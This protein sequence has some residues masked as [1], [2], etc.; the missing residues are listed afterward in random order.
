MGRS[1]HRPW[2]QPTWTPD[3]QLN[4]VEPRQHF[5]WRRNVDLQ[6]TL[7]APGLAGL[8][9]PCLFLGVV[10]GTHEG[11]RLHVP[12]SEVFLA[13]PFPLGELGWCY[14]ASDWDVLHR[15][16][17]I[18]AQ[19]EDVDRRLAKVAHRLPDLARFLIALGIPEVGVTVARVL[20]QH[21]GAIEAIRGASVEQLEAVDGI[22]PKM[23][24]T[25][26]TFL[27]DERNTAAIDAILDRGVVPVGPEPLPDELPDAGAAVFTGTIPIP[28]AAA[29][30]AWRAVGGRTVSSV[31]KKTDYV[32]AGGNAGSKL[33]KAERL[34]LT[35]L[36][37]DAFVD[38]VRELGG[39]VDLP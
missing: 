12:E 10:A 22:G 39:E 24:E 38:K 34:G 23:S 20:A 30:A 31:S 19:R 25:I 13:Y 17:Q 3:F 11:A 4:E 18:L 32:V 28:R 16:P 35:V 2:V 14:P 36:D 9:C 37:F 1:T 7:Y 27:A 29:E 15:R 5:R 6:H 26:T 8:D 21:F 33:E